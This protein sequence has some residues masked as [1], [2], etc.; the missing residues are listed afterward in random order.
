MCMVTKSGNSVVEGPVEE[1]FLLDGD[2]MDNL[3]LYNTFPFRIALHTK[4]IIF[5]NDNWQ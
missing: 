2:K 1:I 5:F 4:C 3:K